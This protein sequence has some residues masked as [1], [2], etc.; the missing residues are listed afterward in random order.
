MNTKYLLLTLLL[1][2][3]TICA[4]N[5]WEQIGPSGGD[6]QNI[7]TANNGDIYIASRNSGLY[8]FKTNGTSWENLTKEFTSNII[9]IA[10][11]SL[12]YLY[13]GAQTGNLLSPI[14]LLRSIDS[15]KTWDQLN[16]NGIQVIYDE[17]DGNLLTNYYGYLLRFNESSLKVDTLLKVNDGNIQAISKFNNIIIIGCSY[18]CYKSIDNGNNWKQINNGLV[19]FAGKE[20]IDEIEKIICTKEGV[21]YELGSAVYKS[22]DYGETWAR[23]NPGFSKDDIALD[24]SGILYGIDFHGSS[25]YSP[26]IQKMEEDKPGIWTD[27]SS[28]G[29]PLEAVWHLN[30]DNNNNLIAGLAYS[31][32]YKYNFSTNSWNE[33]NSGLYGRTIWPLFVTPKGTLLAAEY[34]NHDLFRSIDKGLT[35]DKIIINDQYNYI[36]D[37]ANNSKGEIFMSVY[38]AGLYK[39]TDDGVSWT[40]PLFTNYAGSTAPIGIDS[41]NQI[42]YGGTRD[43]MKST[44]EGM[45]WKSV[46]NHN[47][48]RDLFIDYND[49]IYSCYESNFT[50]GA[51]NPG[52]M[53]SED[54]GNSWVVA[55]EGLKTKNVYYIIGDTKGNLFAYD[56]SSSD[57]MRG[58]S[59]STDDGYAWNQVASKYTLTGFAINSKG[60]VFASAGYDGMIYSD[61]EG[62][63]WKSL[64]E[65][66][67][68]NLLAYSIAIDKEDNIYLGTIGRSAFRM[69]DFLP[70]DI[71]AWKNIIPTTFSLSQNYPNPFNP[72][73]TI[74][75]QI[76][77]NGQ[78]TLK[79]Y[80]ILGREVAMLVNEHKNTGEYQVKFNA[81]NFASG[82]YF[83]HLQAG[84]YSQSKK[85]I[86]MR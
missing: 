44:D 82:V 46:Y 54:G 2:L 60:Y 63:N 10:V 72:K 83:Y 55:N 6:I 59:K 29:L 27:I 36:L 18:G 25:G 30:I 84:T 77:E 45:S 85:M 86:L 12:G 67:P 61:D 32:I 19:S 56:Y 26:K 69:K 78:V 75:Y 64:K 57:D 15:G 5:K 21:F 39:S 28:S 7:Y 76:P 80:D 47:W 13:I 33:S 42:Y 14:E 48:L 38:P 35:W 20:G 73:T 62:A 40:G 79:V 9:S 17:R 23:L 31:G 51:F 41:K 81:S 58:I 24:S 11:S 34:H 74:K 37:Y 65:G 8:R 3:N 68:F 43:L 50:S 16:I 53:K 22:T 52:I 49:N 70:T 4:Q 71:E 1:I 66:L